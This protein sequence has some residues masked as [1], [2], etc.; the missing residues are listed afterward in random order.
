MLAPNRLGRV[1]DDV[2]ERLRYPKGHD[3]QAIFGTILGTVVGAVLG[4]CASYLILLL[5]RRR[6]RQIAKMQIANNLRHWMN[7]VTWQIYEIRNWDASDGHGGAKYSELPDFRFEKSLEQ[8]ALLERE[9]ATEI[10]KLI[11][12]K[13]DANT[14]V[15]GICAYHDE[16]EALDVFR[17]RAAKLWLE[18]LAIYDTVSQSVGWL[19]QAFSDKEKAVMRCE[20]DRLQKREQSQVA[21]NQSLLAKDRG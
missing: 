4:F 2:L 1:N 7:R 12:E 10:F 3:V 11:H 17:G 20:V 14:A 8:V 5:Q 18:A 13:D 6:Q 21:F 15:A 9:T 16:E 19:E